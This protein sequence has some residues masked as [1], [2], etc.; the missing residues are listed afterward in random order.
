MASLVGAEGDGALDLV[1]QQL[2][3]AFA[4]QNFDRDACE[5][6]IIGWAEE[7]AGYLD[8]I[9]AQFHEG[10]GYMLDEG[11]IT[12]LV[13]S[14][15]EAVSA[16][17]PLT[18]GNPQQKAVEIAAC[19]DDAGRLAEL[20]EIYTRLDGGGAEL[21]ST[22]IASMR[23]D[24]RSFAKMEMLFTVAM[25]DAG[26]NLL[27]GFATFLHRL[28]KDVHDQ[29]RKAM[30]V[31]SEAER[32]AEAAAAADAEEEAAGEGKAEDAAGEGEEAKD[33][34]EVEVE[35]EVEKEDSSGSEETVGG[36]GGGGGSGGVRGGR[37][38]KKRRA[39]AAADEEEEE[40]EEEE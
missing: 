33:E 26:G 39:A 12:I 5:A 14:S 3:F 25:R 37:K 9:V 8:L 34:D 15:V 6:F 17:F 36:G 11:E 10:P 27:A 28:C 38:K 18:I 2:V 29:V 31:K 19:G 20:E 7:H 24:P 32:A 1:C 21:V 22:V 40:E 16:V 23:A 30:G 4:E 35:K 13:L